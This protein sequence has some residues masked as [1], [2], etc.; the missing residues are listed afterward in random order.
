MPIRPK[1][2][3]KP[4][5]PKKESGAFTGYTNKNKDFYN[6]KHWKRIR[7]QALERDSYCC[8][9]CMREDKVTEARIVDH[10]K[11]IN[12]NPELKLTLSN[13]QSLCIK[14]NAKKTRSDRTD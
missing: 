5:I 10:I 11:P 4:W 1:E 14:C 2:T 13:M 8:V 6:S 7:L 3:P 12:Q 9:I